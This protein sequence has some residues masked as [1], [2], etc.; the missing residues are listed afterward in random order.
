M[1]Q[2][3]EQS[4]VMTHG[5]NAHAE[6]VNLSKRIGSTTYQVAV[7]FSQSSKTTLEDKLIR[8]IER[9]VDRIA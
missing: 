4:A 6:P 7:H 3:H 2:T 5:G 9:E 1:K 8:I